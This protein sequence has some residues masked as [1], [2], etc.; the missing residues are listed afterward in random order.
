MIQVQ[1][2]IPEIASVVLVADGD[3]GPDVAADLKRHAIEALGAAV[4]AYRMA[5]SESELT[6]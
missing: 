5:V 3:Y 4:L 6:E 1:L 2:H